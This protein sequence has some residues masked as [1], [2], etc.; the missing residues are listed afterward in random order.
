MLVDGS[1]E[2]ALLVRRVSEN[3]GLKFVWMSGVDDAVEYLKKNTP[4]IMF[5]D[6]QMPEKDGFD[7]LQMRA[8][9]EKLM[10]IPTVVFSARKEYTVTQQAFAYGATDYLAKPLVANLFLQ[11]VRKHINVD[12]TKTKHVFASP[13]NTKARISGVL[14][15]MG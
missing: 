3:V 7:M 12:D 13:L 6:L 1:E 2:I 9:S 11:K 8:Q 15:A 10:E 14:K 5:L 4:N